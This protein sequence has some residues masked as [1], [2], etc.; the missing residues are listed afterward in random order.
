[1]EIYTHIAFGCETLFVREE[2][3]FQKSSNVVEKCKGKGIPPY[4]NILKHPL[5]APPSS[6]KIL[7]SCDEPSETVSPKYSDQMHI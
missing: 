4:S 7:T 1:M 2:I 5:S 6:N 3:A